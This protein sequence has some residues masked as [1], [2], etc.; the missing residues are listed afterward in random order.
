MDEEEERGKLDGIMTSGTH[1][2]LIKLSMGA[3]KSSL[4][5]VSHQLETT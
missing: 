1:V 2:H 4:N 5:N 3:T